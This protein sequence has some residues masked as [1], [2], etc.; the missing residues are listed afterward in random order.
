MDSNTGKLIEQVNTLIQQRSLEVFVKESGKV[1]RHQKILNS[2]GET[3]GTHGRAKAN[4]R[5]ERICDQLEYLHILDQVYEI[6]GN[7]AVSIFADI[8]GLDLKCFA[9][10]QKELF[11]SLWQKVQSDEPTLEIINNRNKNYDWGTKLKKA[12]QQTKF[13]CEWTI[14][15]RRLLNVKISERMGRK[16]FCTSE[17]ARERVRNHTDSLKSMFPS[18]KGTE[19][20]R[21]TYC[22]K[23]YK[24]IIQVGGIEAFLLTTIAVEPERFQGV[25]YDEKIFEEWWSDNPMLKEVLPKITQVSKDVKFDL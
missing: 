16:E 10:F 19:W 15:F 8:A 25:N 2:L 18:I 22:Y 20:V 23:C 13:A 1:L 12:H 21:D 4:I 5:L 14:E 17:E 11:R 3:V 7:T 9:G 24:H 6:G